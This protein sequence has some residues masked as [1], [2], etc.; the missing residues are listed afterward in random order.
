MCLLPSIYS[1]LG[2]RVFFKFQVSRLNSTEIRSG[3]SFLSLSILLNRLLFQFHCWI[4]KFGDYFIIP[5]AFLILL[6]H[7]LEILICKFSPISFINSVPSVLLLFSWGH[8][9]GSR[10]FQAS[11]R[12]KLFHFQSILK[13][14]RLKLSLQI[15]SAL[16]K[17][18]RK[19]VTAHVPAT[20][21]L[22]AISCFHF[23]CGG[24]ELLLT[25]K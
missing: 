17:R 11:K 23:L 9:I 20:V 12:L 8:F 2:L 18:C 15:H 16:K 21:E 19:E 5:D 24:Q 3:L 7:L 4:L 25:L 22:E 13:P 6:L 14:R 1:S 10:F